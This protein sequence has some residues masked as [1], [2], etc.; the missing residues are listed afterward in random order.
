MGGW[1][2]GWLVVFRVSRDV[3]L[4]DAFSFCCCSFSFFP[5]SLD[6]FFWFI[7]LF[8]CPIFAPM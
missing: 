6:I 1:L 8:F 2:V 7:M 4:T 5:Q 3:V